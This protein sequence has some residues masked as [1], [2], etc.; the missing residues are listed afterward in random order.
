[1]VQFS[2]LIKCCIIRSFSA[3]TGYT[4][5][6]IHGCL[7]LFWFFFHLSFF[8]CEF[9]FYFSFTR[10][11]WS[12]FK[13]KN[14]KIDGF[15][16]LLLLC[17]IPMSIFLSFF[18]AWH[19]WCWYFETASSYCLIAYDTKYSLHVV[20]AGSGF[21]IRLFFVL[22][23]SLHSKVHYAHFLLY[24]LL[25]TFRLFVDVLRHRHRRHRF[26]FR[27][28]CTLKYIWN[29]FQTANQNELIIPKMVDLFVCRCTFW[30][31]SRI[32]YARTNLTFW[33]ILP[34]LIYMHTHAN[35]QLHTN[36]KGNLDNHTLKQNIHTFICKK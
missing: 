23:Y 13:M 1:M 34:A 15:G 35:T 4:I 22:F 9:D 16:E 20:M 36:A 27:S 29:Q 25:S 14:K 32:K 10:S 3:I 8:L 2:F 6:L 17:F 18:Q 28:H 7:V 5:N 30:L 11:G 19:F 21:F 12:T 31:D 33:Y 24:K 26:R